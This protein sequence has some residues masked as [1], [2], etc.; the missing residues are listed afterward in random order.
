MRAIVEAFVRGLPLDARS[1]RA[2]D[3]A[4][5][6][7]THESTRAESV[8]E[9]FVVHL[10]STLSVGRALAS[11]VVCD[12]SLIPLAWL[13]RRVALFGLLPAVVVSLVESS[14]A[15]LLFDGGVF[16]WIDFVVMVAVTLLPG[17]LP[18][19]LF[20]VAAKRETDRPFP[21]IGIA[22]A[23]F[24]AIVGLVLWIAPFAVWHRSVLLSRFEDWRQVLAPTDFRA[25]P[26][27]WMFVAALGP[28]SVGAG[29]VVIGDAVHHLSDNRRRLALVIAPAVY[30]LALLWTALLAHLVVGRPFSGQFA[31]RLMILYGLQFDRFRPVVVV[32]AVADVLLAAGLIALTTI[33]VGR[34]RRPSQLS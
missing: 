31:S 27:W 9:R 12:L 8:S 7:W 21:A 28:A 33:L 11:V 26:A 23:G 24:V 22:A 2:L 17:W 20:Y 29:L 18:A 16:V 4:L 14:S 25:W 19:A 30:A 5:L 15:R 13:A 34:V 3:E 6:D 32:N 10:R 1:R